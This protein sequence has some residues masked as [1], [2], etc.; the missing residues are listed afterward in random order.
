MTNEQIGRI[1]DTV[2]QAIRLY[3][4]AHLG[5]CTVREDIHSAFLF[6]RHRLKSVPLDQAIV[7]LDFDLY[8]YQNM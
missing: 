1:R 2:Y 5:D 3:P 4:N 8:R 7:D 6:I